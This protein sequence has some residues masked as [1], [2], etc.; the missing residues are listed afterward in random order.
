MEDPRRD[1]GTRRGLRHGTG[2]STETGRHP[3]MQEYG[4][5][6]GIQELATTTV[7]AVV[8]N[9]NADVWHLTAVDGQHLAAFRGNDDHVLGSAEAHLVADRGY[10][11]GEWVRRGPGRYSYRSPE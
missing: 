5:N 10:R 9:T 1:R 8:T 3:P 7:V 4:L 6:H 2:F 11:A